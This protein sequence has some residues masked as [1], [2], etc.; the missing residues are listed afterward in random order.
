MLS[1]SQ[2]QDARMSPKPVHAL[3]ERPMKSLRHPL[4]LMR[5]PLVAEDF[6]AQKVQIIL[7][8]LKLAAA[9]IVLENAG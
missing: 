4:L 9:I 2:R 1:R 6:A 8:A 5:I 3:T 7:A